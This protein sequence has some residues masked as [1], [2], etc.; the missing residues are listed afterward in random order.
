MDKI[1]KA[2]LG[3]S[4]FSSFEANYFTA[5]T[6]PTPKLSLVEEARWMS[7]HRS[8]AFEPGKQLR[9]LKIE[10]V[11]A[12]CLEGTIKNKDQV[13][14]HEDDLLPTP[15]PSNTH[16][17]AQMSIRSPSPTPSN[18]SSSSSEDVVVFR[19][20]NAAPLTQ[21]AVSTTTS[22]P[23]RAMA[24]PAVQVVNTRTEGKRATEPYATPSYTSKQATPTPTQAPA[25]SDTLPPTASS[26]SHNISLP[27]RQT[28]AARG[29]SVLS[30]AT[31]ES[32]P[33]ADAD[34][35]NQVHFE[36]RLGGK[37]A[38]ETNTPEW[39]HRSKPG[40]G[41]TPVGERPAMGP[42]LQGKATPMET[43]Q[44]EF[45]QFEHLYKDPVDAAFEDYKKNII[46]F[47]NDEE[48]AAAIPASFSRRELDLETGDHNDWES[49][50][51]AEIQAQEDGWDADI[52][53]DLDG[54]STSSDVEDII[55]RILRKRTKRSGVQYLVVYEG[56]VADDARWFPSSFLKTPRDLELIRIFEAEALS[57]EKRMAVSSD[58]GSGSSEDE[59]DDTDEEMELIDDERLA[60]IL[61]KQ[62]E[63]G[64][65]SNERLLFGDD[66]FLDDPMDM[67]AILSGHFDRSNKQRRNRA[68]GGKRSQPN[69]P[70]ASVMA[71]V[72]DM[73]PYNGF[74]VMDTERPSLRPR[75]K[76]RRGQMP[77]ELEDSDLNEQLQASWEA[78]RATKRLKKAEREELRK[79]GLLGRKG[80]GPDLSVKHK[81]GFDIH[82]IKEDIRDFMASATQQ[83][84]ILAILFHD[85]AQYSLKIDYL[86]HQWRRSGVP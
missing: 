11:S 82:E 46:Q 73:D 1:Y 42:F 56:S 37:S 45:D 48:M 27:I 50:V 28:P 7:S 66:D 23:I 85:Y 14:K 74:D 5:I 16:A 55:E 61:Q 78:D 81:G 59:S 18:S 63:L 12:G 19:G 67:S 79:A 72:L 25:S 22:L 84:V 36:K 75:K 10:F 71:D 26:L 8:N 4:F 35:V 13:D 33:A 77:P 24:A 29:E 43:T 15:S 57:A 60:R 17:M 65:A 47:D 34:D 39:V 83:Y 9:N 69:F 32:D 86:Y 70:S 38:W 64:L 44:D 40:I 58:E 52:L 80:K 30:V 53:A 21:A 68:R 6:T 76:G 3:R 49:E 31:P 62:E 51:S 2:C 54:M 20:R 41:W